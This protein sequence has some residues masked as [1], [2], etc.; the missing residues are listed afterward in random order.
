MLEAGYSILAFIIMILALI[1]LL[2][3]TVFTVKKSYN[4]VASIK[5]QLVFTT[6]L[7]IL[8]VFKIPIAVI[9][10]KLVVLDIICAV[11]WAICTLLHVIR[12]KEEKEKNLKEKKSEAEKYFL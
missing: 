1:Y 8:I 5:A 12:F 9:L 10:A 3:I 11:L 7:F 2:L 4:E 6:V